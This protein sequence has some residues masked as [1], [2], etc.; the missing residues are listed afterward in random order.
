MI[1]HIDSDHPKPIEQKVCELILKKL[2]VK[3]DDEQILIDKE[4]FIS[5]ILKDIITVAKADGNIEKA[6]KI[7][8]KEQP[9]Y[10]AAPNTKRIEI[11]QAAEEFAIEVEA[12]RYY[13]DLKKEKADELEIYDAV[14]MTLN[15]DDELLSKRLFE[16][17]VEAIGH[18]ITEEVAVAKSASRNE[19]IS[20]YA[21]HVKLI[22]TNDTIDD[23]VEEFYFN[24]EE[25][26]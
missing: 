20:T 2:Y 19:L 21:N 25:F 15:S 22:A 5:M 16:I 1:I 8:L 17:L 6:I 12:Y 4:D 3:V 7:A 26:F 9:H 18:F 10:Q 14:L 11:T 13:L 23:A 24:N